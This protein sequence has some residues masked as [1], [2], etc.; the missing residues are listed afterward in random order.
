MSDTARNRQRISV[1]P[2]IVRKFITPLLTFALA[3]CNV[4]D[5][6]RGLGRPRETA[7]ER[8]ARAL[9]DAGLA[10]SALG[11]EWLAASDSALRAPLFVTLPLREAGF[12]SRSEARAVAYR[13][14]LTDGQRVL[15]TIDVVGQPVH[16]FV[17][18]YE[19]TSDTLHRFVHR[20]SA[21]SADSSAAARVGL[22]YEARRT[23]A[24]VVRIQPELLPADATT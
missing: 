12:Y 7:H 8:Y 11:R 1:L 19:E 21:D 9:T 17:D 4:G 20:A 13:F 14:N 6:V 24:Y 2:Y 23:G 3:A 5:A 16:L 22:N 15:A 10:N 18:L